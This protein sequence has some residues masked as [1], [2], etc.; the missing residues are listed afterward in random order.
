MDDFIDYF[1]TVVVAFILICG[2]INIGA[3]TTEKSMK[4]QIV[5]EGRAEWVANQKGGVEFRWVNVAA[6]DK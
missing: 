3:K 6:K 5:D 4:Q 1:F 2:P